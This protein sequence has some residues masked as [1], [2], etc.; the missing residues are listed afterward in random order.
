MT[1]AT[2]LFVAT[3][4]AMAGCADNPTG[5]A[6]EDDLNPSQ[7]VDGTPDGNDDEN[8][9]DNAQGAD[10]STT[11]P[12]AV[13]DSG[14]GT[15]SPDASTPQPTPDGGM[16]T[17]D[18][19]TS[20]PDDAGGD[21]APEEDGGSLPD[22]P[23]GGAEPDG[24]TEMDAGE[25]DAGEPDAGEP[26]DPCLLDD[27]W[28]LCECPPQTVEGDNGCEPDPSSITMGSGLDAPF[29]SLSVGYPTGQP[30]SLALLI[31]TVPGV[32]LLAIENPTD[33]VRSMFDE[34]GR[35]RT[36]GWL[37]LSPGFDSTINSQGYIG[38]RS[39][40]QLGFNT[41]AEI[42]SDVDGPTLVLQS[43]AEDGE[44]LV[45]TTGADG[46]E[47]TLTVDARGQMAWGSDPS[48]ARSRLSRSTMPSGDVSL[49]ASDSE[50]RTVRLFQQPNIAP[51]TGGGTVDVECRQTLAQLLELLEA[52]GLMAR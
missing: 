19:S 29:T 40:G 5:P 6:T 43:T 25:P 15:E 46:H 41:M 31:E 33:S 26:V 9:V 18:A 35:Y 28:A 14:A 39:L 8:T 49:A 16:P 24:G 38:I 27:R 36:N 3:A 30:A 32:H 20:D 23:D 10:G 47:R 13:V 21:P 22:E 2:Y 42:T 48:D 52:N 51:A 50:G 12:T 1:R 44:L 37:V 11:P 4:L 17:P 34:T 45:G 7:E